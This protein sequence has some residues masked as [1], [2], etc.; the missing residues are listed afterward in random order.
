MVRGTH[1]GGV[2]AWVGAW[3]HGRMGAGVWITPGMQCTLLALA[4]VLSL[5]LPPSCPFPHPPHAGAPASHS[6]YRV[7]AAAPRQPFNVAQLTGS[8]KGQAGNG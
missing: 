6:G 1:G 5:L 8:V 7:T 3:V 4:P 2:P